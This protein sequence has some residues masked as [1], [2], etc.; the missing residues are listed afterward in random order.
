MDGHLFIFSAPSGSGKTTLV[1]WLMDHHPE[2]HLSFSVSC[3]TRQPRGNEKDGVDYYFLTEEAFRQKISEGAFVEYEE[4][5]AGRLYGTLHT[6]VE[7]QLARGNNVVFDVDVVGGCNI[8]RQYGP[9]AVSIFIQPPSILELRHRLV[10]RGTDSPETIENRLAKAEKE[11]S[12]A[13]Q[14]DHIVVNDDLHTAQE[15]VLHIVRSAL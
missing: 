1:R 8:K 4:V 13:P 15:E 9:R 14:F 11:L 6:E 7:S 12:Y 3:T 2:L 5:Y 10:A